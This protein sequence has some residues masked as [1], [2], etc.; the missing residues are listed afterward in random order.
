MTIVYQWYF[1]DSVA[2]YIATTYENIFNKTDEKP[3][4]TIIVSLRGTKS[5]TDTYIDM[6]VDMKAYSNLGQHLPFCGH[7]CRVHKGFHEYY[8][9]TLSLIHQYIIEELQDVEDDYELIIL[10]HSLGGSVAVFLGLNYLDLGYDKLSLIT[11]GQPLIG[12]KPFTEWTDIVFGSISP[13]ESVERKY[14]RVI[15]K[16]D[17]VTVIPSKNKISLDPYWQFDNQIYLNCS[18]GEQNPGQEQVVDCITGE[19]ELCIAK[20]FSL[21]RYI[22]KMLL[23]LHPQNY[24]QTHITYFRRMGFCGII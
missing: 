1:E 7:E 15:H 2:G 12:N 17:I 23:L 21:G 10:G 24:L 20:D 16:E 6:K 3:T 13:P 19:N 11:M 14:L 9:R 18:S 5:I 22:K 8:S 4:K